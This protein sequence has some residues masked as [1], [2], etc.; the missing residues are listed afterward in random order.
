MIRTWPVKY[1][2]TFHTTGTVDADLSPNDQFKRLSQVLTADQRTFPIIGSVVFEDAADAQVVS[3]DLQYDPS[4]CDGSDK[5]VKKPLNP[6]IASKTLLRLLE[7]QLT[8][9][10]A[11]DLKN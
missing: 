5:L 6:K 2:A 3:H 7:T 8:K 11:D 4:I 10:R 9:V 1:T